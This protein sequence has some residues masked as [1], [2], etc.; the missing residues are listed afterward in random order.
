MTSYISKKCLT[1]R[2]TTIVTICFLNLACSLKEKINLFDTSEEMQEEV[3]RLITKG[4]TKQKAEM[5]LKNSKFNC[6]DLKNE[7]FAIKNRDA[8]K[9]FPNQ[10]FVRGDFLMCTTEQSFF[11]A[12]RTWKVFILYKDNKVIVTDAAV[13]WQ[14]L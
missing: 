4:D 8:Y 10:S 9:A 1:R 2:L 5:I 6:E 7:L 13:H 12:S 11:V 14:N 3:S